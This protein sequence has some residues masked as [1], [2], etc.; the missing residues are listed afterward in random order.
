MRPVTQGTANRAFRF[1]SVDNG[2]NFVAVD[3]VGDLAVS[4]QSGWYEPT[5]MTRRE[6]RLP[7]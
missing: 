1:I 5:N 3:E 4:G 6:V 2:A 7:R